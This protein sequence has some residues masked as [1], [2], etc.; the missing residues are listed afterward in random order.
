MKESDTR[1][2][3]TFRMPTG[4]RDGVTDAPSKEASSGEGHWRITTPVAQTGGL[5]TQPHFSTAPGSS[6][7]TDT[8]PSP[9]G[10]ARLAVGFSQP[11]QEPEVSYLHSDAQQ[12]HLTRTLLN[13]VTMPP[14]FDGKR[15]RQWFAEISCYYDSPGFDNEKRTGA[16]PGFLA[17]K[18]LSY[19]GSIDEYSQI[20]GQNTWKDP[21]TLCRR[22]S[23]GR[24]FVAS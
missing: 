5:R 8:R 9:P 10:K 24:R 20:Y 3:S 23:V 17:G 22:G 21:N 19:G 11:V 6:N 13:Q 1:D 12:R 14:R 2:H 4:E 15:P 7:P 16:V 18:E